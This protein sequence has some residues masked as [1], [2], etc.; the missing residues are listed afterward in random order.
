M[1]VEGV[2]Q[3][4]EVSN[5]LFEAVVPFPVDGG[6]VLRR[7]VSILSE[8]N[9]K[10]PFM[11]WFNKNVVEALLQEENLS[12]G[13]RV[14]F[15]SGRAGQGKS[16]LARYIFLHL[17]DEIEYDQSNVRFRPNYTNEIDENLKRFF[18][19]CNAIVKYCQARDLPYKTEAESFK[20]RNFVIIDGIDE[21]NHEKI[22]YLSELIANNKSSLFFITSRSRYCFNQ[23]ANEEIIHQELLLEKLKDRDVHIDVSN[24]SIIL[25][26]MMHQEKKD[27]FQSILKLDEGKK[28]PLLESLVDNDS[29]IL[30]RPADFLLFRAKSPETKAEYLVQH[31]R[32]LI[33]REVKKS[34]E[35]RVLVESLHFPEVLDTKYEF[36]VA[37]ARIQIS[38]GVDEI[39]QEALHL[40][41]LVEVEGIG[42]NSR[43]YLDLTI[44][45]SQALVL[46]S[47]GGFSAHELYYKPKEIDVKK[48]IDTFSDGAGKI[49][50]QACVKDVIEKSYKSQMYDFSALMFNGYTPIWFEDFLKTN[51]PNHRSDDL[52]SL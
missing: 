49:F 2:R 51:K 52:E 20:S 14:F 13:Q 22:I 34:E 8:E 29:Y 17:A 16:T 5:K 19:E 15:L 1:S 24:N 12:Q 11:E 23:V 40:F 26:A 37:E 43:I 4:L 36:N 46:L 45:S 18:E 35:R 33:S 42:R 41:N 44:P 39:S 25:E 50:L 28:Y 21:A 31:L 7:Q 6:E 10:L 47:S 48:C 38:S 32:W 3:L 27:I 9:S 30:Q